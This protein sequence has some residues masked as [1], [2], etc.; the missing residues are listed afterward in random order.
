M[1]E[2]NLSRTFVITIEGT[3]AMA[4]HGA[5]C[6]GLRHPAFTGPSRRLVLHI[7]YE[8]E[9]AMKAED[10]LDDRDIQMIHQVEN[11]ESPHRGLNGIR[12]GP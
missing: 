8:L 11:E 7:V 5:L 9:K 4:V 10:I 3:Y 6:L 12:E 2:K 1:K